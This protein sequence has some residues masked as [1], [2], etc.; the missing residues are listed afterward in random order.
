MRHQ[1]PSVS[2]RLPAAR[3][4]VARI[5]ERADRAELIW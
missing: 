2:D 5:V 1:R 3:V 4:E